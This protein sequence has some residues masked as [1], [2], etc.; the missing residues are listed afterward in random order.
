MTVLDI[1]LALG[2]RQFP[3]FPC[4]AQKKPSIRKSAGGNS[5]YDAVTDPDE[6]KALF[7]RARGAKMVGVPT[8]EATGFDVLDVDYRNGGGSWEAD[9]QHRLPETRV[10]KTLHGG[11]HYVFRHAAGV[12]NT[13]SKLAPGIDVRGTGGYVIMP[14]SGGYTVESDAEPTAWPDWLLE[15]VFAAKVA[16]P[17]DRPPQPAVNLT[18]VRLEG[19]RKHLVNRVST[20]RDGQKH[21]TL[22]NAALSMG[23][24]IDQ[25]GITP[26]DAI[27]MLV[28]ALPSSVEDWG[29]AK[30]TAAWGIEHGRSQP[31]ELPDRPGYVPHFPRNGANLGVASGIGP[32]SNGHDPDP[33]P[34]EP[35]G[36]P[37]IRVLQGLRHHAADAGIAALV[38]AG[39][40]FYQRDTQ[41]VR[42]A[43][44][45]A[46][47]SEGQVIEVP[48]IV[49][50]T[51]PMLARALG[52]SAEW[53]RVKADG[54][55]VRIDPPKEVVEQIG[56]MFG[57]WPFPPLSGVIATPTLRP[58]GSVLAAPG[59]DEATGLV[60]MAPPAMPPIPSQPSKQHALDAL[61]VL[62]EL[63]AE[64]P[65]TGNESRSVAVSMLMTPVLRGALPP[66]VPMHV[67]TA[68]QA[69]TGKSYL[70]D[71]AAA[72]AT[73]ER[74]P[75]QSV[76]PKAEETE[77][78]L[79]GA[80]LA[81]FPIIALDNVS[82]L[83]TGDFLAQVTER[84]L[85]QL[86]PLGGS[87]MVR[88]PNTFTVFA[89]GNNIVATADLVRRTLRCS[90]DADMENPEER[91]FLADPVVAVLANRGKYVAA[92]LTIARAYLAAGSP[93]KCRRLPSYT[94]WSDLVRS[95]L[96]WLGWPDPVE[97][98]DLQ[99]AEDPTRQARADLFNAWH[100][101]L[102]DRG[103]LGL[104][105]S[106]FIA[107]TTNR[108]TLRS[109]CLAIARD[110]NSE[111]ISPE[112]LGKWLRSAVNTRVGN[113]KL[114]VN[115]RDPKR[116]RWQLIALD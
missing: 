46:K 100:E 33:P 60:L 114:Q 51:L 14:P 90:L 80:A 96:V 82:D 15:L 70:L 32:R 75:V 67:V 10:H 50:V 41:L 62:N 16:R 112:R 53:E 74:C 59:Y 45:K 76:A 111:T 28:N 104:L 83:L 115:R 48:G 2:A 31:L 9:N 34:I 57:E 27:D 56:A 20:A 4:N 44:I 25:A 64:F 47:T 97:T 73:G 40:P 89:N 1:A 22:R 52:V 21:E 86:R 12:H 7:A 105:M 95:A 26:A 79:I 8:G 78:R 68:P 110:R 49:R 99:R 17:K 29:N 18:D 55:A 66:A 63:L 13:A 108:P 65:F 92:C 87:A 5:F 72:I 85:L 113:L 11:R 38:T 61:A 102:P 19:L 36:R 98:M 88:I 94:A 24:I 109:A 23:G 6:I 30:K 103:S 84:P 37:V 3:V 39:T 93:N 107:G 71:T 43:P 35:Q 81:G 101:E 58:D 91:D 116:P 69:G 42:T 54:E 106:E 77:K